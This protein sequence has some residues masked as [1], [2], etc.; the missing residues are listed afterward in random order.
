MPLECLTAEQDEAL[1][2]FVRDYYKPGNK[3]MV[4]MI[5]DPD[6]VRTCDL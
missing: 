3:D 2:L 5:I 4:S 1:T 6:R